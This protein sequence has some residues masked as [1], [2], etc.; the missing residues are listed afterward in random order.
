MNIK[1]SINRIETRPPAK[2]RLDAANTPNAIEEKT[3]IS[4]ASGSIA[5][6]LTETAYTSRETYPVRLLTSTDGIFSIQWRPI[7]TIGFTDG[8][9]K[10]IAMKYQEP[11]LV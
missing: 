10:P 6:P 11:P 5:G 3:G 8:K 9:G 4:D 2:K 1:Q 7:K